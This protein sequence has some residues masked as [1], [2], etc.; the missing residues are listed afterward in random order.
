MANEAIGHVRCPWCTS[1]KMRV[2]L[3]KGNGLCVTCSA[4]HFQGFARGQLAEM[5][6]RQA[7]TPVAKLPAPPEPAPGQA[8]EAPGALSVAEERAAVKAAAKAA[9]EPAPKVEEKPAAPA[10]KKWGGFTW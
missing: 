1:A 6:I 3:T 5:S 10:A 4:C 8:I 7:M 2:S 9:P